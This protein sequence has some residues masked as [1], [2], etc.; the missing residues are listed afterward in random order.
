[1]KTSSWIIDTDTLADTTQ[2]AGTCMNAVGVMGPQGIPA[3]DVKAL[4]ENGAGTA[5]RM[6][7]DDD[8]LYYTGRFLGYPDT[9]LAFSPLDDFGTPNAG[10]TRIDYMT[11]PGQFE[12]L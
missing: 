3:G 11:A 7:D 6:Y 1:M 9:E 10:C 8:V 4:K 12:T 5:F 2:P